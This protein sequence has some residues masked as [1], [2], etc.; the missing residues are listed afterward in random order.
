MRRGS[1]EEAGILLRL[2]EEAAME[3]AP[4]LRRDYTRAVL[5][6]LVMIFAI[7]L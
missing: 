7:T 2:R 4:V 6:I 3:D 1:E 5:L